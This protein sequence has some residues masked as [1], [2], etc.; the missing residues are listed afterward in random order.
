MRAMSRRPEQRFP[1]ADAFA[2]ALVE[3]GDADR[4]LPA[5]A[6]ATAGATSTRVLAARRVHET[7]RPRLSRR[8]IGA[9]AAL[10]LAIAVLVGVVAFATHRGGTPPA[11]STPPA[12]AP[13][14]P[15]LRGPFDSLQQAVQR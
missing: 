7:R 6:T 9:L 1:N 13:L 8:M 3:T 15:Q 11:T 10:C 14:P 2:A 5:T 12:T 4:T